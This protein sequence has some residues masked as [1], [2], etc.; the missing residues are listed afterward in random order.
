MH[1]KLFFWK[2][3]WKKSDSRRLHELYG[4]TMFIKQYF[5]VS[6]EFNEA[7]SRRKWEEKPGGTYISFQLIQLD[8]AI[9]T[10]SDSKNG[11]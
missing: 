8:L 6:W 10:E 5:R 4:L 9:L 7:P 3:S 1:L 11:P 2:S